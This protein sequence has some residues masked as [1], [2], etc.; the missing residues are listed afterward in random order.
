MKYHVLLICLLGFSLLPTAFSAVPWLSGWSSRQQFYYQGSTANYQHPLTVKNETGFN[1]ADTFY[2][3][4]E[5]LSSF[6]DLRVT[7]SDGLTLLPIW[8]ETTNAG[9]NVTIWVKFPT[10][11]ASYFLYWSNTKALNIWNSSAVFEREINSNIIL[12][13]PMNEGTGATVYD[14]S[15]NEQDGLLFNTPTWISSGWWGNGLNFDNATSE[16][17]YVNLTSMI[18][19]TNFTVVTY[20]QSLTVDTARRSVLG[21]YHDNDPGAIAHQSFTMHRENT[22]QVTDY[23]FLDNGTIKVAQSVSDENFCFAATWN[24]TYFSQFKNG[25]LS[26]GEITGD[27]VREFNRISFARSYQGY[28][29][30]TGLSGVFVFSECY[31]STILTDMKQ[32]YPMCSEWNLGSLFLRKWGDSPVITNYGDVETLDYSGLAFGVVAFLVACAGL[33][34]VVLKW[35]R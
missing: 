24:T 35:K 19:G 22:G 30:L 14:Y 34:L 6:E 1:G 4:N 26:D 32:Y 8:N 15:G 11:N 28:S 16:Y 13:L 7:S 25:T 27:T 10:P 3:Y 29:N 9:V 12:A 31:N 23:I 17:G 18:D 5:T 20:F 2:I 21:M 33:A